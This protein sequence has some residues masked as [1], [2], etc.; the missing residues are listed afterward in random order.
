M[1]W[2]PKICQSCYEYDAKLLVACGGCKSV[3]YCR[4]ID[5][6][7]HQAARQQHQIE[8]CDQLRIYFH[9]VNSPFHTSIPHGNAL[10]AAATGVTDDKFPADLFQLLNKST[11]ERYTNLPAT[12]SEYDRFV[13]VCNC[14]CVATVLF[15]LIKAAVAV[16]TSTLDVHIV[17]A[18]VEFSLFSRQDCWL[19]FRWLPLNVE[20]IRLHFIGPELMLLID[21]DMEFE[22]DCGATAK[23][24]RI[25]LQLY[26]EVY[27]QCADES[28]ATSPS[29]IV[30][31]NCGFAELDAI[32]N[33]T[34]PW[35]AG[36]R[37]MIRRN[38]GVPIGFTSY[39]RSEAEMDLLVFRSIVDENDLELKVIVDRQ[40]NPYRDMRPLRNWDDDSGEPL[41][42]NNGY[43]SIVL[44]A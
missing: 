40:R 8:C 6:A 5:D 33:R 34:N 15:T 10:M 9:F 1:L 29:C 26:Q 11:N 44:V 13:A 18:S 42:Y 20:H 3:F 43:V 2:F 17:G 19:L 4:H 7:S 27:E 41:F 24:K 28:L 12:Q 38:R 37:A 32:P 39:V 25:T 30:C 36:L 14:S 31:F 22:Y 23:K 21:G 16:T 35:V